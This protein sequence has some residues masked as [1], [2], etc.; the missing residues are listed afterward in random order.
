MIV[1]KQGQPNKI[2]LTSQMFVAKGG[3]AQIFAKGSTI[4]KIYHKKTNAIPKAKIKELQC[5]TK[6]NILNPQS[7]LLDKQRDI[8]GF[9]MARLK[10]TL[11][12]CKLFTNEIWRRLS[13]TIDVV[14]ELVNNLREVTEFIHKNNC[15]IVDG[16][17]FNYLVDSNKI[18]IPYFIDVD[19]YQTPSFPAPMLMPSIRDYNTHGFSELTDWFAFGIVTC[20]LFIGIHPFRGGHPAYK[21]TDLENRMRDGISIFNKEVRVPPPTRDFN[22]IPKHYKEWFIDL[23][24]QNNRIPPPLDAGAI[25]IIPITV[26]IITSSV[27]FDIQQLYK[28]TEDIKHYQVQFGMPVI[29]T[30]KAIHIGK[31]KY[32]VTKGV[33]IIH[34]A[35]SGIPIFV[36]IE[37]EQLQAQSVKGL[38]LSETY[39]QCTDMMITENTLY[40]RYKDKL[41]EIDFLDHNDVIHTIVR[42]S[43]QIMPNSS[44]VF[45]GVVYQNMMGKAYLTVPKRG[46]C[47][48]YAIPEL[49]D[50]K[51]IS[52]K[53]ELDICEVVGFKNNQYDKIIFTFNHTKYAHRII[54]DITDQSINFVV[55][56]NGVVISITDD[57]ME[58]YKRDSNKI[59]KI[60]SAQTNSKMVLCKDGV[61]VRFFTD[62]TLY[63]IKMK[64][65]N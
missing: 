38:P 20:Q 1:Y 29:K 48:H 41:M 21:K 27:D 18:Q 46:S 44:T 39:I 64:G 34:T 45:S 51:I 59:Q 62:N 63:S 16:N 4:Y 60:Q 42:K 31:T 65:G 15:L 54:E 50:Y 2:N 61:S 28:F 36:K 56:E 32:P 58:V 19:S 12:L 22:L 3:Q 30:T 40:I 13:V 11:P 33:E 49:D 37:D 23:F 6:P 25:T 52:A 43:W 24:E 17:E 14:I 8:V 53:C 9:T 7:I 10:N 26:Q 47:I 57:Y 5:L 35:I 55:L